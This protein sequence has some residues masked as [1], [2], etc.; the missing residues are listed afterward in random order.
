MFFLSL[1]SYGIRFKEI[2]QLDLN[3]STVG[4]PKTPSNA[5]LMS[6]S[7]KVLET[8][9]FCSCYLM[10]L[11]PYCKLEQVCRGTELCFQPRR[12]CAAYCS[13]SSLGGSAFACWL[14]ALPPTG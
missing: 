10:S 1:G 9:C 6:Q 4:I 3:L 11:L 2:S 14:Y 5:P 12:P 13:P 7:A 8:P